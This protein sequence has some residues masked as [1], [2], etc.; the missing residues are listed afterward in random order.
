MIAALCSL[1]TSAKLASGDWSADAQIQKM[2]RDAHE[3]LAKAEAFLEY[4]SQI[5]G[6]P[7]RR[8]KPYFVSAGEGG[9]VLGGGWASNISGVSEHDATHLEVL[10]INLEREKE[11]V[12]RCVKAMGLPSQGT[13]R[14]KNSLVIVDENLTIPFVLISV[15]V[16]PKTLTLVDE[17]GNFGCRCKVY[18]PCRIG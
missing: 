11:N 4:A 6:L 16:P 7:P 3:V 9:G 17:K 18:G 5:A 8:E 13:N 12:E 1:I 14:R 10:W 2:E 15:K